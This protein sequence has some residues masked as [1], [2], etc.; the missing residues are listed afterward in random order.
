M[1]PCLPH[2]I[3]IRGPGTGDPVNPQF[4]NLQSKTPNHQSPAI[5]LT[6]PLH[7]LFGLC[8]MIIPLACHIGK[9]KGRKNNRHGGAVYRFRRLVIC[10]KCTFLLRATLF[11]AARSFLSAQNTPFLLGRLISGNGK[12]DRL[13]STSLPLGLPA[14]SGKRY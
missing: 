6:F 11:C 12:N 2:S 1:P 4:F 13:T 14:M 10:L 3:F 9:D 8:I 7:R 5:N